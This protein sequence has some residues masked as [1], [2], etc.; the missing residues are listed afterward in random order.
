VRF[1]SLSV[2]LA[3]VIAHTSPLLAAPLPT[4][5]IADLS[6]PVVGASGKTGFDLLRKIFPDV[7]AGRDGRVL[8]SATQMTDLRSIGFAD[9]SWISCGE[10]IDIK[11]VYAHSL[12]FG[13]QARV[14]LVVALDDE[15]AVPLA[16]F[17]GDG[18]LIDAVNVK[19]D[20]HASTG[21]DVRSLGAA[22]SLIIAHNWHDNSSQSYDAKSLIFAGSNGFSS[23]GDVLA[24]GSRTC[25]G[26]FTEETEIAVVPTGSMARIDAAIVRE[27][28]KFVDDCET[29]IGR[30]VNTTF[31]GY[32]SWNTAKKAYEPHIK[33][34]KLLDAWNQKHF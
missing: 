13:G 6:A 16:M 32:W 7:G 14:I 12:K 4:D 23:I 8:G 22:G 28:V 19:G 9:D 27:A 17:D 3:V 26:Q 33:E 30:A 10:H 15:C 25:R 31:N 11:G 5:D 24:F 2:A 34:L 1:P 18:E 21:D 20:Q 29:K